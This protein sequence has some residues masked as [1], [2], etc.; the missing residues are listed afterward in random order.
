MRSSE[1]LSPSKERTM[2][3]HTDRPVPVPGAAPSTTPAKRRPSTTGY[4]L[5]ALVAVLAIL[6]ALTWGTFTFLGWQ[7]HVE[8]FPRLSPPGTVAVSVTEP[9]TRFL[10]AEHDR[11]T[12]VPSLLPAVTVT[13]PS[14]AFVPLTAYRAEMRYD[15]PHDTNQV[16]DAVLTFQ[17]HEP[18]TYRVTVAT[19]DHGTTVAVGDDL[20]WGWAPRVV[21]TIALL[22]GGLL[23]GLTL[24]VVTAARRSGTT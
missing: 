13:G 5:G 2:R 16:G 8:D 14:G 22:L 4:W 11:S 1:G 23:V 10:Y 3:E 19:A 6:G 17:A 7:A 20:L 9:G 15:V 12:A 18:G 21:A 24:V